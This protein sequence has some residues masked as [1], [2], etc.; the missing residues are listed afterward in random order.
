LYIQ[1]SDQKAFGL[2]LTPLMRGI[3]GYVTRITPDRF[4]GI[5]LWAAKSAE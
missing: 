1:N 3:A 2:Q 4:S 5:G